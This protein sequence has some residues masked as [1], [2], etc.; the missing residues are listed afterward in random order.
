MHFWKDRVRVTI[1]NS[2]RQ[3]TRASITSFWLTRMKSL[4]NFLPLFSSF[5]SHNKN[6]QDEG[7]QSAFEG[8]LA[9]F[10]QR[11]DMNEYR[12]LLEDS[13]KLRT[14]V[15]MK[16]D[17]TEQKLKAL[18][19]ALRA[20]TK[21]EEALDVREGKLDAR[22]AQLNRRND[23]LNAREERLGAQQKRQD[24]YDGTKQPNWFEAR[25]RGDGNGRDT[26][27]H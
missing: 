2:P 14:Q 4:W 1:I 12:Q 5:L 13:E 21:R 18:Q 16:L 26:Q 3:G 20:M 25:R 7:S 9:L 10:V 27:I 23:R 22:E 17:D 19:S 8:A 6:R 11:A 15:R 24:E